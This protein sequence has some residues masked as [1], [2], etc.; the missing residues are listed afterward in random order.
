MYNIHAVSGITEGGVLGVVLLL[1]HWL[2]LSPAYSSLILN[3]ACYFFGWRTLG[4]RFLVYSAAAA[5][6]YSFGYHICEQWPPIYPSIAEM[7]FL[8]AVLGGLCVGICTGICVRIGGAAS[9][10]DAFAMSISKRA[11]IPI[12]WIYLAS[13]L[14]VLL[15]SL[16][17]I[18]ISKISYS[19]LTVVLSGQIIGFIQNFKKAEAMA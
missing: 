12:Q 14:T 5:L 9:G 13:D 15:L 3:A 16:S 17:Y 7:P 10:D 18:P 19:I 1:H 4:K 11:G 8:A 2:G 6:G